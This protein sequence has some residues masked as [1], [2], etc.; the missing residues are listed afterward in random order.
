VTQLVSFTNGLVM[1]PKQEQFVLTKSAFP[2]LGGGIRAGKT[3]ALCWRG[4]LYSLLYPGNRGL[5]GRY[6]L[7]ESKDTLL[8]EWRKCIPEGMYEIASDEG[9]WIITVRTKG[10]PS[11]IEIRPLSDW[12]RFGSAEYGWFG[13]CQA[14]DQHITRDLWRWLTGRL[15]WKLPNGRHP[16]YTGFAE[17]N[18]GSQWI[19]DTWG[20]GDLRDHNE[21]GYE[22]IEI[23]MFDNAPN[24]PAE[25]VESMRTKPEWWKQYFLY[26]CWK[27]L[28]EFAGTPVFKGYF[29]LDFHVAQQDLEPWPGWPIIRGWDLPGLIGTVWFQLSRSGTEC[30]VLHESLARDGEAIQDVKQAVLATSQLLYPGFSMTDYA[31]PAAWTKSPTDQRSCQELLKPEIHLI[32]GEP[33][34]SRRLEAARKWLTRTNA[35]RPALRIDHRCQYM[36]GG[37]AGGYA[38]KQ[39]AGKTVLEPQKNVYSHVIDAFLHGLAAMTVND[40]TPAE[41][42]RAMGP[43][44]PLI[45]NEQDFAPVRRTTGAVFRHAP[46]GRY[47]S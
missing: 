34:A 13:I 17:A 4:Y 41:L 35:G 3:T 21:P 11:T 36:V 6:T 45:P 33:S 7:T 28:T 10:A 5:L 29:N 37:F 40:M 42:R 38:W 16:E 26:M 30:Q 32:P 47:V 20:P 24:L 44:G 27:P 31:D 15:T 23:S 9:G 22:A 18:S 19:I 39:I 12:Q 2:F 14:N 43:A 1:T 8:R 46:R 25:F